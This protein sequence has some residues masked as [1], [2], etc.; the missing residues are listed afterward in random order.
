MLG[1]DTVG[2]RLYYECCLWS[3][4]H[5]CLLCIRATTTTVLCVCAPR[6]LL[7]AAHTAQAPR[8]QSVDASGDTPTGRFTQRPF[9]LRQSHDFT[10]ERRG[11]RGPCEPPR[12][13]QSA[14]LLCLL[15]P[16]KINTSLQYLL[17]GWSAV[18]NHNIT[19]HLTFCRGLRID[20][21]MV[22]PKCSVHSNGADVG[23]KP[24]EEAEIETNASCEEF[25]FRWEENRH[26][27]D[28]MIQVFTIY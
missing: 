11:L 13:R 27:V 1:S 14:V 24:G 12:W 21:R 17:T 4:P 6:N 28:T 8:L 15:S 9:S 23:Q 3:Q 26:V 7:S 19:R 25:L 10:A 20:S 2:Q 5:A 16:W 22:F 18:R